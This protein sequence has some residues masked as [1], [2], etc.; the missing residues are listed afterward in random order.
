MPINQATQTK[1]MLED[2]GFHPFFCFAA[3]Q[4]SLAGVRIHLAF[5]SAAFQL[6]PG[7]EWH[8]LRG[9]LTEIHGDG[10]YEV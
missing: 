8:P 7:Q 5:Q 1:S 2:F 9:G 3:K 10:V 4:S 6:R